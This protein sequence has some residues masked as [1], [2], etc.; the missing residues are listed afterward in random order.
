MIS[1]YNIQPQEVQH[2]ARKIDDLFLG[3]AGNR[4][5]LSYS[6]RKAA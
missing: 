1:F 2:E 6:E 4:N 5:P 3:S